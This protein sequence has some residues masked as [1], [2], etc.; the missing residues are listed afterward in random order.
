MIE[1]YQLVRKH[2][3]GGPQMESSPAALMAFFA[4]QCKEHLHLVLAFSPLGSSLRDSVRYFP[5]LINCCTI[6]WFEVHTAFRVVNLS[7]ELRYYDAF[8][9]LC[10]FFN[11]L[12][13]RRP[14]R[15]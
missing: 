5:S 6:D 7:F 2:R 8:E 13:Q 14:L 12:G 4:Q 9:W 10:F 15:M 1:C 3:Q 11:R